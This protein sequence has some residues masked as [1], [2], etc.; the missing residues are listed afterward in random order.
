M[1]KKDDKVILT[2]RILKSKTIQWTH[3]F[4]KVG[5]GLIF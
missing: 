2:D 4:F 1:I 3:T 5:K